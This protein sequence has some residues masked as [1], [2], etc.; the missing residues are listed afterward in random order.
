VGAPADV[1]LIPA[2][3]R[4]SETKVG[5][6]AANE[7]RGVGDIVN[8]EN[9][10]GASERA[11]GFAADNQPAVEVVDGGGATNAFGIVGEGVPGVSGRGRLRN[12]EVVTCAWVTGVDA[13][14]RRNENFA[15][16]RNERG[17]TDRRAKYMGV[18]RTGAGAGAVVT[19]CRINAGENREVG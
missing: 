9:V 6:Q 19:R 8:A 18:K 5:R 10:I 2:V 13:A 4:I 7:V 16:R 15:K 3:A 17:R 11:R 12:P 1:A 14:A